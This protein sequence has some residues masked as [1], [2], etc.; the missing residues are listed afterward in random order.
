MAGATRLEPLLTAMLTLAKRED[1]PGVA[2]IDG[3]QQ[4]RRDLLPFFRRPGPPS[5][6]AILTSKPKDRDKLK[7]QSDREDGEAEC[8]II[9][10]R[11]ENE[12]G[13]RESECEPI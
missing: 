8:M 7:N 12:A 10:R 6:S 11:H 4:P 9:H 1:D 3:W 13:H 5:F 2:P